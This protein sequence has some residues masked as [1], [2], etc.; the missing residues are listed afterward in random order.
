M[1]INHI[2]AAGVIICILSASAAAFSGAS[3][4]TN[5]LLWTDNSEN[6]VLRSIWNDKITIPDL[7]LIT[8]SEITS[9]V[10]IEGGGSAEISQGANFVATRQNNGLYALLGSLSSSASGSG[11]SDLKSSVTFQSSSKI[12][13]PWGDI[14]AMSK[15]EADLFG[16]AMAR[17]G[18]D[19][20]LLYTDARYNIVTNAPI[21]IRDDR[22][23]NPKSI[24]VSMDIDEIKF[25]EPV[26]YIDQ[27]IDVTFATNGYDLVVGT[28]FSRTIE[29]DDMAFSS[30]M[31]YI[32]S[33]LGD[34][35]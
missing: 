13:N 33:G 4:S 32:N 18:T 22:P 9:E 31:T 34:G 30:Q 16:L 29:N 23:I 12:L 2:V 17:P 7:E 20:Y 10:D 3:L 11:I 28:D 24:S 19:D 8:S 15:V 6:S 5:S 27:D 1:P 26:D 14:D 25:D 21:I 35:S